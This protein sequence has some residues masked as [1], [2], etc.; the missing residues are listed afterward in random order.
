MKVRFI[1]PDF[2]GRG[3]TT[4][5]MREA[6]QGALFVWCTSNLRYPRD[7]ARSIWR[8]DLVI[9]SGEGMWRHL[10]KRFSAVV[11]DHACDPSNEENELANALR[12][13]RGKHGR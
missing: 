11:F 12:M 3:T 7:L 9:V 1:D 10:G 8:C 4:Q 6:P 5:Q 13:P 2:R